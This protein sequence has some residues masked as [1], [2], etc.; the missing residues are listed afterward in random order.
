M[1]NLLLLKEQLVTTEDEDEDV[2]DKAS[3]RAEI[4]RGARAF[5]KLLM[6]RT[7]DWTAWRTVII[8]LRALRNLAFAQARTSD[9]SSY[10]YRQ[11]MSHLLQ[12]REYAVY[13]RIDK[14]TRS[15]CYKLMDNLDE[16]NTWY[17]TQNPED[18]MQWKHPQTIAKHA[19][20]NL[21]AGGKGGNKPKNA[22]KKKPV[23]YEVDRL[24]ALLIKVIKRLMEHEPDAKELLDQVAAPADPDDDLDGI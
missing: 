11:A 9:I 3:I 8:G 18:Q 5:N 20:L 12:R 10:A 24:R 15:A 19:P 6:R 21:V 23:P 4:A 22:S 17:S 13:D 14:P 7:E 2:L 16:I 1:D